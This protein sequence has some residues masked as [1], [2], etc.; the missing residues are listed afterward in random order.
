[1]TAGEAAGLA[2][3][4]GALADSNSVF[5]LDVGPPVRVLT[6]PGDSRG[7][8]RREVSIE[9][10][11]LRP[12]ERLH[13]R[14]LWADDDRRA[15]GLPRVFRSPLRRVDPRWLE[16]SLAALRR[17]RRRR[18]R[19]DVR[20]PLAAM[21]S[22]AEAACRRPER[23]DDRRCRRPGGT[24]RRHADRFRPP[25]HAAGHG[26]T[27]AASGAPPEQRVRD[28]GRR[29]VG[30]R[31][32]SSTSAAAR[33]GSRRQSSRPA[34]RRTSGSTSRRRCC[35][36]PATRLARLR[37]GRAHRRELP[38]PRA[39]AH[40][41]RRA[42]A[43]PLRLPRRT[44]ARGRWMR[45]HCASTLVATFTRRDRVKAPIR[46]LHYE[47]FNRCPIFDYTEARCRGAAEGARVFARVE[48]A[49]RGPRGFFVAASRS[50]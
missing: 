15:D 38:R 13:E 29:A 41:R 9:F 2:I 45:A 17:L 28:L 7:V 32:A 3:V 1:M 42:R 10:V 37:A 24:S 27:P 46:H 48:F 8:D 23:P 35:R 21:H 14:M 49:S 6:S 33:A 44:G 19:R 25:L 5:W 22:R 34:Q 26:D 16:A 39:R 47:V 50:P 18:G 43:R 20:A 4:A 30:P 36:S 12:G 31:R 11:G 40:L